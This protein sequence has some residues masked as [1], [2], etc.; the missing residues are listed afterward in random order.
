LSEALV[1]GCEPAAVAA[2]ESESL[3]PAFPD[4]P[5]AVLCAHRFHRRLA[6]LALRPDVSGDVRAG[7]VRGFLACF[8][9][10]LLIG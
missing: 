6:G 8:W 10:V 7:C 9:T 5:V 3:P 4:L 2:L 1:W